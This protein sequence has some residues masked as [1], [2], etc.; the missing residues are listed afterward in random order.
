MSFRIRKT[1][2]QT[3]AILLRLQGFTYQE[4]GNRLKVTRQQ[5]QNLIEP[6]CPVRKVIR[7]RS[8]GKCEKCGCAT[9]NGH[10]HHKQEKG[11]L[12]ENFNDPGNLQYL[13]TS[14]HMHEHSRISESSSLFNIVVDEKTGQRI[15]GIA[16]RDERTFSQVIRFAMRD[17]IE[18]HPRPESQ[19]VVT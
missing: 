14:C 7:E 16:K 13:C 4:I 18:K 3:S 2:R 12:E 1:A 19:Q 17:F 5:A 10:I 11:Q 8:L 6:S 15:E 9:P